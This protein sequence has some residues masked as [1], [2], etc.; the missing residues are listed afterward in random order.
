M[1]SASKNSSGRTPDSGFLRGTSSRAEKWIKLMTCP[2]APSHFGHNGS[3]AALEDWFDPRRLQDD[4]EPTRAV[5]GH[6]FE[7]DLREDERMALIA[8]S[9]TL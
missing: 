1:A 5:K 9:K 2:L 8:F 4:Y 7:L 3:C 6:E